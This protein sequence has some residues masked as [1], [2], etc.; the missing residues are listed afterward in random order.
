MRNHVQIV[1]E[2]L[3]DVAGL[4]STFNPREFA[5]TVS[6]NPAPIEYL[7]GDS[8]RS[9]EAVI[10]LLSGRENIGDVLSL[11]ARH[12]ATSFLYLSPQFPPSAAF[13]RVVARDGGAIL[14]ATESPV[15]I[16]A[17]LISLMFQ[18]EPASA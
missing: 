5:V 9:P 17:S 7:L 10:V 4:A 15:V 3:G 1:G 8:G 6:E 11:H 18:R 14:R 13:A 2:S 16:A 12:P